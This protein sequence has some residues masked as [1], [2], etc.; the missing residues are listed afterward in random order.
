MAPDCAEQSW[1]LQP[2]YTCGPS[3]ARGQPKLDGSALL[4]KT[5]GIVEVALIAYE[6]AL[7]LRAGSLG[8]K[9]FCGSRVR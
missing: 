9:E 4:T 6:D 1:L 8:I 5:I 2:A 7:R 3:K